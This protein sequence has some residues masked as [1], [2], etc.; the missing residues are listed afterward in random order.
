VVGADQ[1]DGFVRQAEY[2]RDAHLAQ[3]LKRLAMYGPLPIMGFAGVNHARSGSNLVV[4]KLIGLSYL[5]HGGTG[6]QALLTPRRMALAA[7]AH[8]MFQDAALVHDDLM[9]RSNTRRGRRSLHRYY[10]GV[11]EES[12]WLGEPARMGRCLALMIG[13]CLLAASGDLFYEALDAIHGEMA[14]YLVALHQTTRVEQ[15]M[16]QSFDTILPYLPGMEDPDKVIQN[17]LDT[18]RAKTARYLAG[19]PLALGAAGAGANRAEADIMMN[20]GLAL[21]EAYQ[22]K[23]DLV[24]AL[25]D[26]ELSG[27]PV[28]QDLIDG[29]RTVLV[30]LTLRLLELKERRAFAG[31]LLRGDAP[32]VEAR[33]RHLQAVIQASGAVEEL[34]EMIAGRRQQAFEILDSSVLDVSGRQAVREMAD[35]LLAPARA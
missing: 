35:W 30:G 11:H 8:E 13:D 19:T 18:L 15:L 31:A 29:K 22:L 14:D 12:N 33:V 9:D 5:A 17:A 27:K 21:G 26:P 7:T 10:A 20:V 24:G 32:P 3:T 23:D 6:P 16:G 25:G 34:E 28:G 4:T 2:E 1:I